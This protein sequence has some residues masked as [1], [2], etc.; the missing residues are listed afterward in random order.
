V[1]GSHGAGAKDKAAKERNG[2]DRQ[3]AA[4]VEGYEAC[5]EERRVMT[6]VRLELES[7]RILLQRINKREKLKRDGKNPR[8]HLFPRPYPPHGQQQQ[9]PRPAG[10]DQRVREAET[11]LPPPYSRSFE[12]A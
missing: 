3:A 2:L 9:P 1:Q 7:L 5:V 4:A 12:L 11:G 8:S 10:G 6:R